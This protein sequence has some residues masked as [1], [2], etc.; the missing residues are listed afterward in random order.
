MKGHGKPLWAIVLVAIAVTTVGMAGSAAEK[1]KRATTPA[2]RAE[3]GLLAPEF[4]LAGPNGTAIRLGDYRG[5]KAVFL[6]FWA[7]WCPSCQAEMPTMERVHQEFRDRGV[8]ILAVSIDQDPKAAEAFMERHRLTFPIAFDPKMEVADR[9]LVKFIPTH[10]FIDRE[11]RIVSK[12]VGPRE[13]GD[14]STW[15]I[16]ESLLR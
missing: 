16:L 5:K 12:E 15:K 7:S 3:V 4:T 10:Y 8:E 13:W 9:Y 14:P 11:G 2:A 1:P 6:N